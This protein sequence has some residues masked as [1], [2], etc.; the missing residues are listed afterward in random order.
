M[1]VRPLMPLLLLML[2]VSQ[3]CVG[4]MSNAGTM[5]SIV[6]V[7]FNVKTLRASTLLLGEEMERTCCFYTAIFLSDVKHNL[8]MWCLIFPNKYMF[9]VDK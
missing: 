2:Q 7:Q 9:S 5:C 1:N 3:G 6:C 4:M 8:G